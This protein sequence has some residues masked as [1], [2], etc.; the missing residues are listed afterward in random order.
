[1]IA[2]LILF[3][4]LQLADVVTTLRAFARNPAAYEAN[5]ALRWLMRLLGPLPALIVVKAVAIA[6]VVT[7]GLTHPRAPVAL[8]ITGA[9][10]AFYIWLVWNNWRQGNRSR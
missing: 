9:L 10:C 2:L 6:A 3:G 5:P 8:A 1:M 4:V 7:L